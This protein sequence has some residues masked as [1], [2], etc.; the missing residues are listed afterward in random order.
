MVF[1]LC[2]LGDL[3]VRRIWFLTQRA[4]RAR[5]FEFYRGGLVFT[6]RIL[7]GWSEIFEMVFGDMKS[8]S[9]NKTLATAADVA[10]ERR[11]VRSNILFPSDAGAHAAVRELF[12]SACECMSFV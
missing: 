7:D 2:G 4:Q 6:A 10:V 1:V 5:R 11:S 8:F 9:L 12:R 3:G